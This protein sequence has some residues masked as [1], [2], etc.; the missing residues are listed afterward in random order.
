VSPID[1]CS[2]QESRARPRPH[3][4]LPI[5]CSGKP[6]HG[7]GRCS[8]ET[9]SARPSQ[10]RGHFGPKTSATPAPASA[11]RPR[12]YP[13]PIQPGHL[14]SL[15]GARRLLE[16][17][18]DSRLIGSRCVKHRVSLSLTKTVANVMWENQL[19][20][21]TVPKHGSPYRAASRGASRKN[22]TFN[23][24]QGAFHLR[25]LNPHGSW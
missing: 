5:C 13:N 15:P 8:C 4:T 22:P 6:P 7:G 23:R 12:I 24:T 14:L 1:F 21:L 16:V 3:Q 18:D 20:Q 2:C 17:D 10:L 9:A 11:R 19:A 25:D